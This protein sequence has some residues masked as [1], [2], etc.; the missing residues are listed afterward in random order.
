MQEKDK[1]ETVKPRE[2]IG[3]F[4]VTKEINH[5][6]F[7]EIF[8]GINIKSNCEVAIKRECAN[9]RH[10]QL[11][12]EA[13]LYS[14]LHNDV[15]AFSKGIPRIY[16]AGCENKAN[17][18]VMDLMGP[19]LEDVFNTCS[20]KLSL[21]S[22]LM[23]TDQIFNII[24]YVH[25][26]G[27]VHRDIKPDNFLMGRNKHEDKVFVVDFGLAKKIISGGKH[28]IFRDGKSLTGTA[29]YASVNNHI[30][31]E[32]SRRDDMEAIAYMLIYFIKGKLPWQNLPAT[33]KKEKF[34]RILE[35]KMSI[36]AEKLCAGLPKEFETFLTYSKGLKFEEAPDYKMLKG[37]FQDL[38]KRE[39]IKYDNAY[40]WKSVKLSKKEEEKKAADAL[41]IE[42]I[43]NENLKNQAAKVNTST[44]PS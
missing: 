42:Q 43:K 29:R 33:N 36:T 2:R 34:Q 35:K 41:I 12:Y 13:K 40:D 15:I 19:S 3:N 27:I 30:G 21:K 39:G 24:E 1:K 18:M 26:R 6:A 25:S 20:R 31:Y 7:G 14:Y 17:V 4:V 22:T 37:I 16:Y 8:H 28:L 44:T 11:F 38:A 5:G 10:P 23:L 32:Q 9:T